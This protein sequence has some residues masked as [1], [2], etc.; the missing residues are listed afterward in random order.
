MSRPETLT[1]W[2][3]G[4][5]LFGT[6]LGRLTDEEFDVPSLLPGWDRRHVLAHVARNADALVNL[7]T[8]ARTGVRTPMYPTPEARD[9]GIAE[10][11]ALQAPALRAQVLAATARLAD[12]VQGLPE[13]AWSAQVETAQGRAVPA[14]EVPWMRCREVYVHAVDLDAGV[15]FGDVAEEV[16]AAMVDDVFRMWDRR[17]QVPDVVVFAGD[18]EWGTGAVAVSGP[19]P[20]VTGWLTGRSRGEGLTADG[21][22]PEVPA[23]L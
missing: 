22:I 21:G 17:D 19:L 14:A 5:R 7:L 23:W 9:A 20:A 6:A 11:A 13:E 8:W 10:S 16:Q 3:D 1:W 12:A 4:E 18:R 2:A 15:G